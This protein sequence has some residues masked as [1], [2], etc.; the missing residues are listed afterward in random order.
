MFIRKD[1]WEEK[2]T[3]NRI[4]LKDKE[5]KM[6]II[7][8]LKLKNIKLESEVSNLRHNEEIMKDRIDWLDN[9]NDILLKTNMRLNMWINKIIDEFGYVDVYDRQSIKIP[10][11]RKFDIRAIDKQPVP[12]MDHEEIIIPEIRFIKMRQDNE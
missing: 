8:D 11:C 6:K 9:N 4:L 5:E 12:F 2:C 7:D 3:T 1:E 10:L